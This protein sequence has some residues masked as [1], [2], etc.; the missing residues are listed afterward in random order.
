MKP[1]E[2]IM[3]KTRSGLICGQTAS[4]WVTTALDQH[5]RPAPAKLR[6]FHKLA[7]QRPALKPADAFFFYPR[8][9][10]RKQRLVGGLSARNSHL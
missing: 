3:A 7:S 6:Q 8:L 5:P 10:F 2:G 1:A 9:R 4:A